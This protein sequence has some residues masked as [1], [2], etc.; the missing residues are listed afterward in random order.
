MLLQVEAS[1]YQSN[2]LYA[3]ESR[4]TE[5]LMMWLD[6]D[7]RCKLCNKQFLPCTSWK[8]RFDRH[9]TTHTAD[10]PFNCPFCKHTS[11]RK[12]SLKMHVQRKHGVETTNKHEWKQILRS[13]TTSNNYVFN[14]SLLSENSSH[15]SFSDIL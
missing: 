8:Q 2:Q 12:D 10:K 15:G 11:N 6:E 4:S 9:L 7:R 1:S 13:I 14:N 5:Q 3:Q